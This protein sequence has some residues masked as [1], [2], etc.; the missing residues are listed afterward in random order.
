MEVFYYFVEVG[1]VL[2]SSRW[3]SECADIW[4]PPQRFK[5]ASPNLQV[6]RNHLGIA[7]GGYGSGYGFSRAESGLR[8]R[9]RQVREGERW[10]GWEA[11]ARKRQACAVTGS[12]WRTVSLPGQSQRGQAGLRHQQSEQK[13]VFPTAL[14]QVRCLSLASIVASGPELNLEV[15]SPWCAQNLSW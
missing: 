13:D 4:V 8:F 3:K 7:R 6:Q 10:W 15:V 2:G 11:V 12:G 1:A 14:S 9:R 5:E